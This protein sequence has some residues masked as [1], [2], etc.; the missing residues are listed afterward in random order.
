M[1]NLILLTAMSLIAVITS[2]E[3][4]N[5][6][7]EP[8]PVID[9]S[10]TPDVN[11]GDMLGTYEM[12]TLINENCDDS[13]DSAFWDIENNDCQLSGVNFPCAGVF[14][15]WTM[16]ADNT[17]SFLLSINVLGSET[18][19]GT[20]EILSGNKIQTCDDNNVCETMS[21]TYSDGRLEM[22]GVDSLTGC[23]VIINLEKQ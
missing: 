15:R 11:Q 7:P 19:T 18:V 20:Y 2:C 21:F 1:K 10:D 13:D 14:G 9:M 3:E 4:E 5:I 23:D 6:T 17:Y 12:R 8:N 22:S 16:N